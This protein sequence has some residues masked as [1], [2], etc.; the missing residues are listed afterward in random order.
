M[1][2]A[3][4]ISPSSDGSL[5]E[6]IT[7]RQFIVDPYPTYRILRESAPVYYS[8]AW[9][10]WI[11]SRYDDIVRVLRDPK[12]FSNAGRFSGLI[13]RLPADVGG[14][15]TALRHHYSAG[16]IQSDPPD[17]TRLRT[18]VRDAFS[19]S[20]LQRLRPRIQ[21]IID[22]LIEVF[23]QSG[24]FNVVRDFAYPLP[25][26]VISELLGVPAEHR[27]RFLIWSHDITG[28]QAT[29]GANADC[30]RRANRAIQE[31][32]DY[33]R[34]ICAE[35]RRNRQDDLI[36]YMIAAQDSGD[37]LSDDELINMCVT[38]LLA[39]HETTKNLIANAILTLISYPEQLAALRENP[40]IFPSAIE[41]FLRY[42]SPIQRG[43]RRVAEDVEL[44]GRQVA[45]GELV[46]LMFGSANRDPAQFP[47]PDR[48]DLRRINNR[49]IAF[50]YGVHFCIGAP[51]ARLEAPLALGTLLNRLPALRLEHLEWH[52]SVH[53]R[54]P[55]RLEV[56]F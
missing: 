44:N 9:R 45:A 18:L 38:F 29:G 42:E 10:V 19:A 15:M 31:V 5:D 32:E 2:L 34:E 51:L 14:E 22:E 55:S 27:D 52:E 50:G 24:R 48:L 33:F 20:T 25:V 16:L 53:V 23:R 26:I 28:L 21:S 17:H 11:L 1:S 7:A 39:G 37:K 3:H 30:A 49:H 46:F 43:W 12:R 6:L 47:E 13:D 40:S 56:T 4:P 8:P 41:E 36:S 35:R 54:G